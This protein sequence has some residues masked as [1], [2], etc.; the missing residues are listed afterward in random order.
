MAFGT[1]IVED[2]LEQEIAQMVHH[3][4]LI[5][6][7]IAT[8]PNALPQRYILLL[9]ITV[10]P[11]NG[12][13]L[14]ALETSLQLTDANIKFLNFGLFILMTHLKVLYLKIHMKIL[15]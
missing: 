12:D 10:L 1:P 14:L 6:Q 5:Q 2:W 13:W 4:G 7:P 3:K 11:H 15:Q 9:A 8:W